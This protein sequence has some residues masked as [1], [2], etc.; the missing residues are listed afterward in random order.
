M[1]DNDND[2]NSANPDNNGGKIESL[3]ERSARLEAEAARLAGGISQ[4][5]P[6]AVEA[7]PPEAPQNT[8]ALEALQAELNTARDQTLRALAEAENSRKRAAREREDASKYAI[9]NFARDLLGV[10]DNLRRAL[11][12]VPV[13]LLSD[14]RVKALLDGIDATERELLKAFEKSGIRKIEPVGETFNPNFHEVIFEAPGTGQPA[15]MIVQVIEAGYV[16][17]DRLLR[18]AR[19]GVAKNETPGGMPGDHIIDT[20]A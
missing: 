18:P 5:Q 11:E 7:P 14:E 6:V 16:L 17:N 8:A 15:G 19:V 13:D 10:S 1:T 12:A 4:E 20:K 3:Q 9:S 2:M